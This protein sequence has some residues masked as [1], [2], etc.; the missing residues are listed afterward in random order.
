MPRRRH[1]EILLDG[2]DLADDH[3]R[4]ALDERLH[5]GDLDPRVDE[6][7]RDRGGRQVRLDE[8]TQPA[9][10]DLHAANCARKRMS[11]SKKSRMS[12]IS[13]LSMATRSTPMPKAQPVTSSGS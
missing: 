13:Y 12:S 8:F 3:A 4:Q 1:A 11:F 7:V 10:R 9:V 5:G 2:L 6:T